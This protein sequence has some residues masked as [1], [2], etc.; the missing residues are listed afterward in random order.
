M[1]HPHLENDTDQ[2]NGFGK[3]FLVLK[4]L[5]LGP[6]SQPLAEAITSKVE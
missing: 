4:Y 1:R 3:S 2:L 5:T 6:A